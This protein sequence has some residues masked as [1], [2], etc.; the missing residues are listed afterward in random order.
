MAQRPKRGGTRAAGPSEPGRAGGLLGGRLDLLGLHIDLG[1]LIESP[2]EVRE[3]LEAL[4]ERLKAAGAREVLDDDAWTSGG[5]SVSGV[6]RTR[7]VLGDREF[8]VGTAGPAGSRPGRPAP[9][10]EAETVEPP[11]DVFDEEAEVVVVADVPGAAMEDLDVR[12]EGRVLT[13][14]TRSGTRY[15][16]R[17]RLELAADV[18]AAGMRTSCRNGVLE[19]R[20][21]KRAP[22]P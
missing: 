8:H 14:A 4:R 5:A 3:G 7:G 11:M 1:K 10:A 6:I 19:V 22:A 16:Y 18:D 17:K 20:L 2:E 12:V 21:P 13:V 9:R 15:R